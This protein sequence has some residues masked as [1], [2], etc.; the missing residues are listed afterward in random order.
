M[1]G[2]LARKLRRRIDRARLPAVARQVRS[3]GLTYLS[4]ERMSSLIAEVKRLGSLNIEGDLAEFGMAMG[5]SAIVLAELRGVR[6]FAGYDLF[7]T[8]PPPGQRDGA[9]AHS[10]YEIIAS[11]QST[12]LAG[13]QYYGYQD[14]LYSTVVASFERHGLQVDQSD[15]VLHKGLF[16]ETFVPSPSDRLAL[17]HVDCDWY[18]PVHYCLTNISP[19]L[20][21]GG[22]IIVDDFGDYEGCR[23]AV[24]KV[25]GDDPS[26]TLVRTTPHAVI[27][28]L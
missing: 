18:D 14:D 20:S 27:R 25:L 5:G 10:R 15:I 24:E 6:R 1:L 21:P 9:D 26:L 4:V 8:I 23:H 22:T 28:K 13:K 17:A 16:E 3:E 19:I 7:G 11:G 2:K 12:G